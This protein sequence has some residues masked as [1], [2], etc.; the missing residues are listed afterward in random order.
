MKEK[1]VES[2]TLDNKFNNLN[3]K[4]KTLKIEKKN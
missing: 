2:V 1:Q 4:K 3:E